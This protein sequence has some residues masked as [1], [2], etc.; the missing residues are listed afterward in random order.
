MILI[1]KYKDAS[2]AA[3]LDSL[4]YVQ[5][6]IDL[7]IKFLQ[8]DKLEYDTDYKSTANLPILSLD[9]ILNKEL[10]LFCYLDYLSILD[11]E[12]YVIFYLKARGM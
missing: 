9:E 4:K 11:L 5:E 2:A 10:T 1:Q 6:L 12:C 8:D 7:R 3:E